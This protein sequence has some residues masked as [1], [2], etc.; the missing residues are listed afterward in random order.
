MTERTQANVLQWA[1]DSFGEPCRDPRE[2]ASRLVEEAIEIAQVADV[3]VARLEAIIERIYSR[4][5]GELWQ[6]VGG[7]MITLQAFCENAGLDL[8]ECAE[9]EW[10]RVLSKS[11]EWWKRKHNA[12]LEAGTTNIPV[13]E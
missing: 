10:L 11:P 1:V 8:E 5:P 6:E 13:K 3:P 12:K 7:T 2:R 4:P 9:R